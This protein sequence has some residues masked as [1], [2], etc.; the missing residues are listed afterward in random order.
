VNKQ[1]LND[2][3]LEITDEVWAKIVPMLPPRKKKI[4]KGRPRINDRQAMASIFYKLATDC[5]WKA[6]PS[7]M[8][9]GSTIFDRYQ[10]WLKAGV[11]DKLRLA[12]I[13]QIDDEAS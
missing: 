3:S 6:L 1:P 5:S 9:A 2:E 11:F 13:L 10:E 7:G 12:G 4:K 8:G